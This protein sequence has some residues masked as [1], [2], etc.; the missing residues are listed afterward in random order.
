VDKINNDLP[1]LK[2]NQNQADALIDFRYNVGHLSKELIT[3]CEKNDI[4]GMENAIKNSTS[5]RKNKILKR[6]KKR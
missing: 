2:V 1:D 4:E 6:F 3:A 5:T